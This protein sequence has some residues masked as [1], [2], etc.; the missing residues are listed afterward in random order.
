MVTPHEVEGI[1]TEAAF[2]VTMTEKVLAGISSVLTTT[3]TGS[4]GCPV[5]KFFFDFAS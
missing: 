1:F 5:A 2:E 3:P 4:Y